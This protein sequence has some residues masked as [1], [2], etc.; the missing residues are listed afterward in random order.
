MEIIHKAR[1]PRL[2]S[3]ASPTKLHPTL[4]EITSACLLISLCAVNHQR[5]EIIARPLTRTEAKINWLLYDKNLSGS[6]CK[7]KKG[8]GEG[9]RADK[10]RLHRDPPS[11][12]WSEGALGQRTS[13]S[14][15]LISYSQAISGI[16]HIQTELT[17][18]NP[19]LC[20][21]RGLFGEV[22]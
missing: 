3:E 19:R 22:A 16:S 12:E 4:R 14:V 20:P 11:F 5:G 6:G 17:G 8:G 15:N 9:S 18:N 7:K 1:K 13:S 10:V 2:V 21:D